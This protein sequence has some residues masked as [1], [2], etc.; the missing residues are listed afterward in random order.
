MGKRVLYTVLD[1][2]WIFVRFSPTKR[3]SKKLG[4]RRN[5]SDTASFACNSSLL[6]IGTVIGKAWDSLKLSLRYWVLYFKTCTWS[7][8]LE[9]KML[10]ITIKQN[11]CKRKMSALVKLHQTLKINLVN[12][13]ISKFTGKFRKFSHWNSVFKLRKFSEIHRNSVTEIQDDVSILPD[14]LARGKN[15]Q[16]KKTLTKEGP[17]KKKSFTLC[18][19]YNSENI[20]AKTIY[21]L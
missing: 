14:D 2:F 3:A 15:E 18:G 11:S 9:R 20:F 4:I 19:K 6:S 13:E 8:I 5:N 7:L 21:I 1:T 10:L 12:S 16:K 17:F